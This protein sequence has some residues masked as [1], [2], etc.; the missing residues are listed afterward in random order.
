[1]RKSILLLVALFLL[2][3]ANAVNA[4]DDTLRVLFLGNSYTG[5][6]NLPRL[7]IDL[8]Q[9]GGRTVH[10]EAVT[11]GGY[12]LEDHSSFTPSLTQISL[13]TW[14]YVVLQEQS[15][16]PTI[17]YYRYNSMYPSAEYLDTLIKS[18]GNDRTTFFMT[19][20]RKYG[21]QQSIGAYS[22]PVFSDFFHMQDSLSSAYTQIADELSAE[23][24]PVGNAWATAL[25]LDPEVDLWQP[26]NSHPTLKGSYLAACVFYIT[27]FDISPVGLSYTA[28]LSIEDALFLQNAA[29]RTMNVNHYKPTPQIDS[30]L[31]CQTYPNPF[32]SSTV[33]KFTTPTAGILN[34][35]VYNTQG[36]LICTPFDGWRDSGAHE[37][38]FDAEKLTSGIYFYRLRFGESHFTSKITLIK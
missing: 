7:L 11:P 10:T 12:W 18:C 19:W 17:D 8:S 37:I 26:D 27:F 36:R 9:S 16:V 6:N 3:G 20:G 23:L 30:F 22:S 2:V 25:T 29:A 38:A 31:Q 14:D 32:N 1:M 35:T 34:I 21:G 33:I 4:Q 28:G 5:S 24:S 15:Q 13:G